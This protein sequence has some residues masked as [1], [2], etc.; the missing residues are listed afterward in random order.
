MSNKFFIFF[1][2]LTAGFAQAQQ[3]NCTVTVNSNSIANANTNTFKTLERSIAEFVNKTDWTGTEYK[4]SERIE[5]SMYITLNTYDSNNYSATIQIQAARPVYNSTYSSPIFNYNDKDLTFTYVEFQN[6]TYDPTSYSS[7]LVSVLSFYAYMIL[8]IDGDTFA[9]QGGSQWLETAQEICN[10]AQ[11][12]GSKGWTQSDGNQ[13]RYFL[14]NDMLSNTFS[15]FREA[16]YQYHF[17]G[18]DAMAKDTKL[19]KQKVAESIDTLSKIYSVRPNA[20]LTRVFF[21]AKSDEIVSIFSGGPAIAAS[22]LPD[23]LNKLS[24]LN[25]GKWAAIK[26]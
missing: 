14:V 6:L 2:L 20:F 18:L 13:N 23:N 12:G 1:A 26:F 4:Q 15:P 3:L 17:E 22:N 16:M 11:Q 10:V 25:S 21:D 8:G 24:P 9:P 5:C 7:N 19:A